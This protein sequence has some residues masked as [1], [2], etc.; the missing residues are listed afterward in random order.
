MVGIAVRGQASVDR[1]GGYRWV[2]LALC[3]LAFTMTVADHAVWGPTAL[4]A[5][6]GLAWALA[7][8]SVF[9]VGY[10]LG[11]LLFTAVGGFLTDWLGGR[12]IVGSSLV[13]GAALMVL[14]GQATST[15]A[16]IVFQACVGLFAGA[17]YSAG[18]KLIAQ[19]FAPTRRGFATGVFMTATSL[20]T[21]LA[22]TTAPLLVEW[23]GEQASYYVFG[24]ASTLVAVLCLVFLRDGTA[25]GDRPGRL[26]DPR[27]VVRDRDLLVLGAAG[28]GALWGASGFVTWAGV[29]MVR[30]GQVAPIQAGVVVT[31][32][33]IAAVVTK[34]LVGLASDLSGGKRKVPIIVALGGFVVTLLVFGAG[35]DLTAF[36]W[37]APFLGIAAYASSPLMVALVPGLSGPARAGSAS[38][39]TNAMWQ[40]GAV[41]APL[42]VSAV[43][44]A[45]GS[46]FLVFA[47]LAAGPFAGLLLMLLVREHRAVH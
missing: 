44:D 38:G 13:A 35:S 3:W 18:V 27:P 9:V 45:T 28:F 43:F 7:G 29:A 23:A 15:A 37:T 22:T 1:R 47:T 40:L 14:F 2:V 42:V 11:Y 17:S 12:V 41:A 34:P 25:A 6:A 33:V 10:Y 4:S 16:G 24:G 21:V 19:W 36:L 20:G 46:F 32:F 5:S 26:P 8:L 30:G 39:L 31:I